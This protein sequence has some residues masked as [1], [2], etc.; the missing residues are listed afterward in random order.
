MANV[1]KAASTGGYNSMTVQDMM[2]RAVE[3][4]FG[5]T[6]PDKPVQWLTDNGSA[7]TT[8]GT[9][10]FAT[11][12]NLEAYTTAASSPRVRHGRAV[13]EDDEGRLHRVH[14]K[15]ECANGAAEPC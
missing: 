4:R 7:Y 13:R 2:L 8:H 5:V 14:A 3:K 10:K 11:E 15:T 1:A 6:L 12:L 9:R